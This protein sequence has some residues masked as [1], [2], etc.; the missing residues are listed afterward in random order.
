MQY[1]DLD[2]FPSSSSSSSLSSVRFSHPMKHARTFTL[3][4]FH[5]ISYRTRNFLTH[6]LT[7]FLAMIPD[8]IDVIAI[9]Q[10]D[11]CIRDLRERENYG[12]ERTRNFELNLVRRERRK[13]KGKKEKKDFLTSF[14]LFKYESWRC[15]EWNESGRE[16]GQTKLSEL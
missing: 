3:I 2:F 14:P 1:L 6:F 11:K 10:R 7:H 16:G 4:F 13:K 9:M 8:P 15:R 12:R 5:V